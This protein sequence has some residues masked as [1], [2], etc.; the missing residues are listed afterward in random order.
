MQQTK[1]LKSAGSLTIGLFLIG[2]Y[3]Y[4]VLPILSSETILMFVENLGIFGPLFVIV[5]LIFSHVFAPLVGSPA[6][7]I[8]LTLYGF[9]V[10]GAMFFVGSAV[11]SA[12]CFYLSRRYGRK[13]VKKLSGQKVLEKI[14]DLSLTSEVNG[15]VIARVLGPSV[16]DVVSYAAGLTKIK[17]KTYYAI[18]LIVNAAQYTVMVFAFKNLDFRTPKGIFTYYAVMGGIMVLFTLAFALKKQVGKKS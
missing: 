8:S 11:S 17:F 7:I 15:L 1:L 12:I 16:F 4:Y 13:I 9:A 10:T 14:D 2:L 5:Y 6:F 3:V 18:T